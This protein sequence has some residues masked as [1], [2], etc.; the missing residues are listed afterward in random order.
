MIAEKLAYAEKILTEANG[1][2]C[3]VK[4]N[5][6]GPT[7][8]HASEGKEK[9][10]SPNSL[11]DQAERVLN[12]A[13]SVLQQALDVQESLFGGERSPEQS[14]PVGTFPGQIGNARALRG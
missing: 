4:I 3:A 2:L 12:L 1:R 6:T 10:T 8:T 5:V 9:T 13:Q 7:P 11:H 14:G